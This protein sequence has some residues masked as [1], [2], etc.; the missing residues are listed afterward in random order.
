MGVCGSNTAVAK[1]AGEKQDDNSKTLTR[2]SDYLMQEM[3]NNCMDKLTD[4]DCINMLHILTI[5]YWK[6]I[7]FESNDNGHE[8]HHNH[9]ILIPQDLVTIITKYL[10]LKFVYSP[11]QSTIHPETKIDEGLLDLLPPKQ[12]EISDD[13]AILTITSQGVHCERISHIAH[14]TICCILRG[15]IKT[16]KKTLVLKLDETLIHSTFKPIPNPDFVVP[17]EIDRVV[18]HVYVSK[19]PHVDEFLMRMSKLYELVIW[20]ASLAKYADKVIDQLD[21]NNKLIPKTHRL[22]REA[23][24]IHGTAYVRDLRRLGREMKDIIFISTGP[25]TYVFTPSNCTSVSSWF[26]DMNDTEL[27]DVCPVL[28]TTLYN[29][30][31]V[32]W[33]LDS[34]NKSFKWLCDQ[35]NEPLSKYKEHGLQI[36]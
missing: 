11:T 29:I 4:I 23:C 22:F 31:D 19:R 6:S 15:D 5:G 36:L 9:L 18:H 10:F 30:D 17:V 28:E 8:S 27:L 16:K 1:D 13:V 32:R 7:Y 3:C 35:S 21:P 34:N 12:P 26:D 2:Q 24:T 33:I 25:G 14:D 20:T